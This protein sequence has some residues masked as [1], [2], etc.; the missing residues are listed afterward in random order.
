MKNIIIILL[1]VLIIYN[2]LFYSEN[3]EKFTTVSNESVQNIASIYNNNKITVSNLE[4]TQNISVGNNASV[5]NTLT[6][7]T[8]NTSNLTGSGGLSISNPNGVTITRPT[9]GTGNLV[10]QGNSTVQ[11]NSITNGRLSV[12]GVTTLS[13]NTNISG[14]L[15]VTGPIYAPNSIPT[16]Y[17]LDSGAGSYPIFGS[18]GNLEN[19]R[20]WGTVGDKD[21]A[22]I[23]TP[24]YRIIIYKD[25]NFAGNTLTLDNTGGTSARTWFFTARENQTNSVKVFNSAG[26][27][28][29]NP[30]PIGMAYP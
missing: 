11:G 2:F 29:T 3:F 13:S 21:D 9:G 23:V 8:I 26:T 14:S 16:C 22:W 4:T 18:I 20:Q 19:I 7:P 30:T 17:M 24:G 15:N 25:P 1:V 6:S 12:T 28:I 5:V 10:V 27:E